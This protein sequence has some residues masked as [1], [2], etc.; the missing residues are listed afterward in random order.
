MP[1]SFR[2]RVL[3]TNPLL[4]PDDLH[5]LVKRALSDDTKG[6]GQSHYQITEDASAALVLQVVEDA[7]RLLGALEVSA[8]LAA[9]QARKCI[10]KDDVE[11]AISRRVLLL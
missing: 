2:C 6:L 1:H 8:D 11:Q 7:R 9:A 4:S 10:E 3:K 5:H